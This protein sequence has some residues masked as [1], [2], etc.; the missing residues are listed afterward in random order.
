MDSETQRTPIDMKELH[1]ASAAGKCFICELID[2]NPEFEHEIIC[3]TDHAVAFL[4]KFPTMFGYCLVAPKRH[5]EQV[6]GDFSEAEYLDLQRVIYRMG[7][8]IR[9]ALAPERVYILSL[10]SQQANAHVHWHIAPL[11]PGVPLAQQQYHALMHENGVVTPS[12]E[13]CAD[14]VRRVRKLLGDV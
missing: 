4:S 8:A 9:K 10:G 3:E 5:L 1:R 12:E 11:Q 14:F 7:E 2:R 6:T 13:S